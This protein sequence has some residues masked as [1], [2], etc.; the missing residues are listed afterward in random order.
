MPYADMGQDFQALYQRTATAMVNVNYSHGASAK[1]KELS[2]IADEWLA[3]NA[4]TSTMK[5]I[6]VINMSFFFVAPM[7]NSLLSIHPGRALLWIN[8]AASRWYS[9]SVP[10]M[11]S[12]ARK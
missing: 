8:S 10:T 1:V 9:G 12:L 3:L 5:T 4:M 11:S 6:L 7:D 2:R